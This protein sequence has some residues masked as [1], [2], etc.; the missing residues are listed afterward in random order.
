MKTL[1]KITVFILAGWLGASCSISYSFSGS[2]VDYTKVASISIRDFP[3]VASLVYAPLA[4]QFTEN[5]K[6][7]YTRQTKLRVLREGGDMDLEG[8]ITGYNFMPMAVSENTYASQTRLT[9]T[10]RVRFTNKTDP[11]QDFER[12]FTAKSEFDNTSSID[13]VQ[14]ELC[15]VIMKEI[16]DQI[17]N[18]TV[19]TW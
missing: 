7:K 13:Q 14:D 3:N 8:E 5:L 9:I 6:D 4:Q 17:Y 2:S 19:A 11:N 10:V 18:A 15:D 16:I 1:L 12:T